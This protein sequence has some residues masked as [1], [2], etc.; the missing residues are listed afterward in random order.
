MKKA[1][2][3]GCCRWSARGL[4]HGRSGALEHTDKA[5]SRP[6]KAAN[7]AQGSRAVAAGMKLNRVVEATEI[8]TGM[9]IERR[10]GLEWYRG[11]LRRPGYLGGGLRYT[12]L[13]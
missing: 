12:F 10:L 7:S 4:Q 5:E 9:Y 1:Q 13:L 3:A 2:G 11:N 8:R 6:R